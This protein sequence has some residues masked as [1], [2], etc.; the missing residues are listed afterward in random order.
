MRR[1][2]A[3]SL[4]ADYD[5]ADRAEIAAKVESAEEDAKD[6]VWASYRFVVIADSQ[7]DDRL[8]VIDLGAG[9]ASSNE[10]LCGRILTALK[11]Q[12]LLN[13]SVGA[14]YLDRKWPKALKE[15]GAWPLQGLRQS[16]LDGSLTRLP[17]PDRILRQ[18]IVEFVDKGEFGLASGVEPDGRYQRVWYGEVV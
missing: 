9:H 1:K 3:Q 7:A 10:T 14:G 6:E 8:Q 13:E 17:D 16:F 5:K 12:E 4:G 15:S 11:S 18:K 2:S